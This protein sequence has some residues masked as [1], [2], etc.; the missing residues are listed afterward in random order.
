MLMNA[1]NIPKSGKH[2][3][4]AQ[5]RAWGAFGGASCRW[6]HLTEEQYRA[7]DEAAK[8]ENRRRHLPRG[9]RINGQNLFTEINSHQA[10]LGLPPY[11][12][13]PERPAFSFDHL[14]PLMAGDGRDGFSLKL[15]V[16]KRPTGH[17]LVFGARPC[18]PGR[19]YCDKLRYLGLLPAPKGGLSN[20]TARYCERHGV[21]WPGS[22]VIIATQQQVDGWRDLPRRLDVIVPVWH[23]PATK[24]NRRRTPAGAYTTQ[25]LPKGH[26]S[27]TQGLPNGYPRE[28]H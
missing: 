10:F 23:G 28:Q 15:R 21:P 6:G 20:I 9:H 3:T 2:G 27:A 7:W 1:S 16:P 13:P 11:L 12:F 25:G 5:D 24:P 22:R 14:G 17:I 8:K 18:S 26:L 4:F 19:R